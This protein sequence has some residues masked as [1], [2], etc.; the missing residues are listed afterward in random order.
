[1]SYIRRMYYKSPYFK[2]CWSIH[3]SKRLTNDEN[4]LITAQ[5]KIKVIAKIAFPLSIIILLK[6]VSVCLHSSRKTFHTRQRMHHILLHK[7]CISALHIHFLLT[8]S[9]RPYCTYLHNREPSSCILSSFRLSDCLDM[10]YNMLSRLHNIQS[11]HQC[12][13]YMSRPITLKIGD[14]KSSQCRR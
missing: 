9:M 3:R 7:C 11:M 12:R 8:L 1:M 13:P 6:N 4:C 10:K 5:H 2:V 14:Y